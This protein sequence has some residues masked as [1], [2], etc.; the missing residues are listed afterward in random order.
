[1][2][3]LR[4]WW[5]RLCG[6]FGSEQ[7]EQDFAAEME[8]HLQMHIED[9]LLSG[10][11][12][13]QARR[14]AN[15]KLGGLE[16]TKQAYRE[17]QG[18]PWIETLWQ[19]IR[20]GLRM[21]GKNPGFTSVAVLTLALGIGANTT[22]F[23][24]IDALYLKPLAVPHPEQLV[25]IYAKGPSGHYGAGFSYSE[26]R[27]LRDHSSSFAALSAETQIAQLHLVGDN[28][29]EEIRGTFVSANYF[30]L[31]GIQPRLG[32]SFLPEEDTAPGRDAVAVISDRIWKTHFNSDP[33][34]VGREIHVNGIPIKVIGIAPPGFHGDLTGFP[35]EI[36]LP[37]M[38][39]GA[40]GFACQDGSYECSLFDA[41][42][43]RLAPDQFATRAQAEASSLIVWSATNWPE[44][45]SRR[46]LVI[47]SARAGD[48][49]VQPDSVAQ[50]HLL[51]S[52]TATLLFIVCANLA[53]LFLARGATRRKEIALRLSIGAKRFRIIRQLL[54]ESLLLASM[55]GALGLGF[56]FWAK[57][58]LSKFYAT[59]SEGFH[60]LYD[61]SFDWRVLVYSVAVALITGIFFGLIPAIRASGQN[62]ITELKEGVSVEPQTGG[63]LRHGLVIGQ[64]ALSMVLVVSAGLLARSG[65]ELEQGTNFDAAHTVVLRLR[66]ELIKYTP[67]QV[68]SLVRQLDQRL[69]TAP[70]VESVAFMEGGE[71]LVWNWRN[72]R[73]VQV[74]LPGQSRAPLGAGFTVHKQDVDP[75]FFHT[76]RIPLL[77]G[78]VFSEQDNA[79]SSRVAIVNEALARRLWTVGSAVG[80]TAL[81]DG[82]P[83]QIV[84]VSADIQPPSPIYA[85]EPHLYLSY[86][87][88]N[89]TREGDIRMAVLVAREPVLV[90]PAI[91]RMIQ[92]LDPN[93]PIG[94]DMSLSEQVGLEYMPVLLARTITFYCGLLALCMSAMGLYS[95]LAFAVRTRTREIGIRMALGALPKDV[96]R[97]V[98]GQGTKLTLA[99]VMIGTGAALALTRLIASLLFGV[100]TTDPATYISVAL[101]LFLVGFAACYLPARKATRLDPV[102]ALR[103][104]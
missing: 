37:T 41:M 34:T 98:L 97:V 8:S 30:T 44:R 53:G 67:Q 18:L 79:R 75:N 99:G 20:F 87:Q 74:N 59:D 48:P 6:T 85:P 11:T 92:S 63:W 49:D 100:K 10:L 15:L 46:Q 24:L 25:R 96:L 33:A 72:G 2:R 26:F 7:R 69:S 90:L 101:L 47:T 35:V 40:T 29:S 39:L 78:R 42:I 93:V 103:T 94:E 38:M 16:Q 62:L 3:R 64:V 9:N 86:W 73:E 23:T 77:R 58:L 76:L 50:M 70:G 31:L 84:G 1:M 81:I 65:L 22:I 80:R 66:P 32:R 71:G 83:F 28:D 51:M 60:H 104:E 5:I 89:A 19:D 45:S 68:E 56:S 43:G 95:V 21:I 88:S 27:L 82:Q 57:H 12:P 17:R 52:V 55:G 36:W 61:L 54:T 13:E 91:R 4:A 14:N 102:Q